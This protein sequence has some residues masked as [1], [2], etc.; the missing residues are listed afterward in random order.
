M[1][2]YEVKTP[3]LIYSTFKANSEAE[4][5]EAAERIFRQSQLVANKDSFRFEL[6]EAISLE[7]ARRPEPN[8]WGVIETSCGVSIETCLRC[9]VNP[10]DVRV[11]TRD[12]KKLGFCAECLGIVIER[13]I[14]SGQ[15]TIRES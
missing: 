15:L 8:R 3:L 12:D 11:R 14:S 5:V 10:Q 13:A 9:N 1:Q 6:S 4:A 2:E 7:T